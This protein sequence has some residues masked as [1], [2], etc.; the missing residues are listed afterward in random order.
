MRVLERVRRSSGKRLATYICSV[1]SSMPIE[2]IDWADENRGGSSDV[3]ERIN[4]FVQPSSSST[5][6]CQSR[7]G[8]NNELSLID[9][10][11]ETSELCA[12]NNLATALLFSSARMPAESKKRG[13]RRIGYG[14]SRKKN[15]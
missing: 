14:I 1:D 7:R 8:K 10:Q 2:R 13:E 3:G 11:Q 12:E 5:V 15:E 4:L 6:G 9:V